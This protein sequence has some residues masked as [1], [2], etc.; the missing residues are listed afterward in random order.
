MRRV[1]LS[2][3]LMTISS[4]SN[5]V[6]EKFEDQRVI[7]SCSQP[8][9]AISSAVGEVIITITEDYNGCVIYSDVARSKNSRG[10]LFGI[11]QDVI[12]REIQFS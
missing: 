5:A 10:T 4:T 12:K 9:M 7:R 8:A 6:E 2:I 11:I 1:L 3:V